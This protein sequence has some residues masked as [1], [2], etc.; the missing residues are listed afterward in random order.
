M[1]IARIIKPESALYK[2]LSESIKKCDGWMNLKPFSWFA[3]WVMMSSGMNAQIHYINRYSYWDMELTLVGLLKIVIITLIMMYVIRKEKIKFSGN[4]INLSF[5]GNQSLLF[6]LLF[7][8]GWGWEKMILGDFLH[9]LKASIPYWCTYLAIIFG[10]QI[11]L[12]SIAEKGYQ[13][14]KGLILSSFILTATAAIIGILFDD[15][16]ISTASAVIAPF[17]LIA[18]VFPQHK[19]HIER[20]RTY[21]VFTGLFFVSVRL[22]WL[23]IPSLALF[24]ALRI[25]HYFRFNIIYPTFAVH[26]D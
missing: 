26:H 6:L 23:L 11:N 14:G 22:P 21:P 5:I 9:A 3:I 8:T 10:F 2:K 15:P 4:T 13:P 1:I 17:Y 16:V 25:Y 20:C 19:R 7:V 12:E 24:F 18:W